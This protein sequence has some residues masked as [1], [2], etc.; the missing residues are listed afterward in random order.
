MVSTMEGKLEELRRE[1]EKVMREQA[2][3]DGEGEEWKS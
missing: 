3:Q 1:I 2:Q